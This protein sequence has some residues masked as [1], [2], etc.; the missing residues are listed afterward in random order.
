[1]VKFRNLLFWSQLKIRTEF[2]RAFQSKSN[3]NEVGN[4]SFNQT[5]FQ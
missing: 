1:M 4:K 2:Q 5:V 3:Q